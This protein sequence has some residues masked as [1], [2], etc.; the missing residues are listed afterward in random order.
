MEKEERGVNNR[1]KGGRE[2]GNSEGYYTNAANFSC[3]FNVL[4]TQ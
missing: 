2:G 3:I 1:K 4:Y